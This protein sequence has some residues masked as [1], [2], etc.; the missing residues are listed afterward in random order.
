M[1][2]I[3]KIPSPTGFHRLNTP[4]KV[5]SIMGVDN[6]FSEDGELRGEIF[7]IH[8][9][10]MR[11]EVNYIRHYNDDTSRLFLCS[12]IVTLKKPTFS[13]SKVPVIGNKDRYVVS[14]DIKV[15]REV[16]VT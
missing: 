2:Y 8:D 3:E 16:K 13:L 4:I 6:I 7:D 1:Y 5:N 12:E 15:N 14:I 11:L 10:G 9:K